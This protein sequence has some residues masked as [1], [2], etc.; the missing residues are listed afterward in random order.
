M[1]L[2]TIVVAVFLCVVVIL[3]SVPTPR[4]AFATVPTP[5]AQ[6]TGAPGESNCTSCHGGGSGN[7]IF[8]LTTLPALIT[9]YIPGQTYNF[10]LGLIDPG[11]VRFG[12]EVTALR[13]SDNSPAGT[14]DTF[15]DSRVT[16]VSGGGRTYVC[17]T[18]NGVT[19][20]SDPPDPQD[21]TW[22]S[23]TPSS[24]PA[25][26]AFQWTAPAAGTG[27]VT[28]YASGVSANGNN[29]DSG[30][31]GYFGSMTLTEGVPSA[32]VPMTWGKI[33][34]RYR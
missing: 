34:E 22:W 25:V 18:T 17:H 27:D 3:A 16:T 32:V 1:K 13:D 2:V 24:D 15:I 14:F 8:Q 31:F 29:D 7:E 10:G 19:S 12:F 23:A 26:W 4:N 30:D 5:P 6:R 11:M 20:P 33:K 21:G 28:F 9:E